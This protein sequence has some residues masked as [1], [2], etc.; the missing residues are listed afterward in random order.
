MSCELIIECFLK[1]PLEIKAA[2]HP[3]QVVWQQVQAGGSAE[4]MQF[5]GHFHLSLDPASGGDA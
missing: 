1:K 5:M 2:L 3:N 4:Q